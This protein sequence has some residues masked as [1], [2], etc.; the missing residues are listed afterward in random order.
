MPYY[1][2]IALHGGYL[3]SPPPL[4]SFLFFLETDASSKEEITAASKQVKTIYCP[5]AMSVRGLD[6]RCLEEMTRA[7]SCSTKKSAPFVY[8]TYLY[9][10]RELAYKCGWEEKKNSST[11]AL[12]FLSWAFTQVPASAPWIW[13]EK[14]GARSE[15]KSSHPYTSAQRSP[16]YLLPCSLWA[17]YIKLHV[18]WCKKSHS[19]VSFPNI[20]LGNNILNNN[21]LLMSVIR[22]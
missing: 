19:K 13:G 20:K 9:P 7:R 3:F 11:T 21:W 12:I 1:M 2:N 16:L 5:G 22:N 8:I 4:A 6:S 14:N 17:N 18:M 15:N 10:F